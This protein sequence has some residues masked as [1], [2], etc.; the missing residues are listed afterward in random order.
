M[1]V[2][3]FNLRD[4]DSKLLSRVILGIP[5]NFDVQYEFR[6]VMCKNILLHPTL[7]TFADVRLKPL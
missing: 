6:T 2:K 5:N 1:I 3:I 7:Y 4:I